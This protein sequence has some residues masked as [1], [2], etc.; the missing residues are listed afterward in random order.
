MIEVFLDGISDNMAL[1]V[2]YG[3][4][5]AMNTTDT[6]TMVYY[7]IKYVSYDYILQEDITCSGKIITAVEIIVKS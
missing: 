2:Q 6:T 4:Y 3:K 7:V 1:L 5:C